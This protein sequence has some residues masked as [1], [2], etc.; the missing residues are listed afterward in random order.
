MLGLCLFAASRSLGMQTRSAVQDFPLRGKRHPKYQRQGG[1]AAA[2]PCS[3]P[4]WEQS[5]REGEEKGCEKYVPGASDHQ[6]VKFNGIFF[7][8]VAYSRCLWGARILQQSWHH[9]GKG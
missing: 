2:E 1:I 7:L 9:R 5:V 4:S 6:G 3:Q 8:C